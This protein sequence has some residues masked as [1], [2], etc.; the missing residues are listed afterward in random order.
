[1]LSCLFLLINRLVN[2]IFPLPFTL[3]QIFND[4]LIINND[5]RTTDALSFIK[6]ELDRMNE[7]YFDELDK[8]L[9]KMWFGQIILSSCKLVLPTGIYLN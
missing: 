1:M 7:E 6:V 4:A 2:L 5:C 9:Q 3:Y 8:R